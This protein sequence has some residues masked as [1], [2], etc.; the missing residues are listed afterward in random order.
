MES[1]AK[2]HVGYKYFTMLSLLYLTVMVASTSLAYKPVDI[3]G[4]TATSSSLLFAFT[5]A[6]SSIIAEVYGAKVSRSLVNQI[7]PCGLIFSLLVTTIP[8]LPSPKSWHHQ[9][10]FNYVFGNSFRFAIFGTIGSFISYK[11]NIFLITRWK[12]LTRGK[13]FILRSIGANTCG[14][15]FLVFITTFGAFYGVYPIKQVISMFIFAYLSKI[16]YAIILSW[17]SAI[18]AVCIKRREYKYE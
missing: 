7:I 8:H 18:I 15:F 5:F 2:T 12:V 13:K 14:E 6:I 11:L 17:P 10:A 1:S 9:S 4:I 16:I 3:E